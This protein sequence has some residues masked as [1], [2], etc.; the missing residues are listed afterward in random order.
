[1]LRGNL[2]SLLSSGYFDGWA[3]DT[4][5][6]HSPL[7][8]IVKDETGAALAEGLAHLF[9]PDLAKAGLGA[10]W[11]AFRLR[12]DAPVSRVCKSA[13]TV[14]E[15]ASLTPITHPVRPQLVETVEIELRTV[16]EVASLDP[17]HLGLVSRLEGC[18]AI[19]DDFVKSR[20]VAAF[21]RAA[22]VYVLQRPADPDGLALYGRLLRQGAI[23]P[24]AVIETLATSTEFRSQPR[25]LV[26]P[27]APGFPFRS[28]Q[29]VA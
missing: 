3:C 9:R 29:D 22:Y 5:R 7:H 27:N 2:D 25:N 16:F 6:P 12:T 23:A 26:A 14:F 13:V 10:G 24:S 11:C 28:A 4:E 21:I 19:F 20:G 15:A 8:L 18:G 1:M 17:T